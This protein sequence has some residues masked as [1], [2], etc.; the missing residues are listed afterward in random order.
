MSKKIRLVALAVM[1]LVTVVLMGFGTEAAS[2][3][4]TT[5][6][7]PVDDLGGCFNVDNWDQ[8]IA[9]GIIRTTIVE[10][11]FTRDGVNVGTLQ[12]HTTADFR[13]MGK[14]VMVGGPLGREGVIH[15]ELSG[16]MKIIDSD[17]RTVDQW[18]WSKVTVDF[19]EGLSETF[20]SAVVG[21][22]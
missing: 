7:V 17:G 8:P 6:C 14:K 15:W 18:S 2:P 1:I 13:N 5:E 3:E 10:P 4:T 22:R 11:D 12:G 16:Q 20:D 19:P 21:P 9:P